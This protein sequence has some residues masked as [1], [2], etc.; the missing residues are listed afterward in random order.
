M[1]LLEVIAQADV[2][3]PNQIPAETKAG[4][5]FEQEEGFAEMMG[6]EVKNPY[7][8][9]TE[10]LIDNSYGVC[11]VWQLCARIDLANKDLELY[12][13]DRQI[14]E[15][16]TAKAK[17]HYRRSHRGAESAWRAMK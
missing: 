10:M 3:R 8:E 6:K 12:A 15:E 5:V 17:A 2:L 16:V 13:A 11:Y 1:T 9:N 14:A 7:P 4:W